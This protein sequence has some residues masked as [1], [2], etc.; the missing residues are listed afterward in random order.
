MFDNPL[1]Y[2]ER[3]ITAKEQLVVGKMYDIKHKES[4]EISAGR[5]RILSLNERR[6]NLISVELITPTTAT[7]TE[8][9]LPDFGIAAFP[10]GKWRRGTWLEPVE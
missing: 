5:F 6:L 1:K 2:V 7:E 9:Y 10:D 4:P 3:Q 8:I